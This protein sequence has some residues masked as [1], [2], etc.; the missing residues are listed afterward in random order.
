[1]LTPKDTAV[2]T[3]KTSPESPQN[4]PSAGK[5]DGIC[6]L[7]LFRKQS[8]TNVHA[9]ENGLKTTLPPPQM[10]SPRGFAEVL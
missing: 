5:S 3:T 10:D 2:K 7:L 6:V 1:M 8:T 4:P 9:D